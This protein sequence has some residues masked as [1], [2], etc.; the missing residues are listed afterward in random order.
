MLSLAFFSHLQILYACIVSVK[1]F[2][3]IFIRNKVVARG[4]YIRW[5]LWACCARLKKNVFSMCWNV[6]LQ[7][8]IGAFHQEIDL[9]FS[10]CNWLFWVEIRHQCNLF[11][12]NEKI[13]NLHFTPNWIQVIALIDGNSEYVAHVWRK[14]G[15]FWRSVTAFDLN[16]CLEQIK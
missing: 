7:K 1:Y 12:L 2:L 14:M 5:L 6:W 15:I 9:T 3:W 10:E 13:K 16:K 8:E 11:S 4:I